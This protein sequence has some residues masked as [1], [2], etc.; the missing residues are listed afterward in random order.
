MFSQHP[1]G[2]LYRISTNAQSITYSA[3]HTNTHTQNKNFKKKGKTA[4]RYI[5][6]KR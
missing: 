4:I 2:K 1:Q 5:K 3:E 6:R